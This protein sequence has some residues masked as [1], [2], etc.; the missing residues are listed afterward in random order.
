MGK[1]GLPLVLAANRGNLCGG[2]GKRTQV[3]AAGPDGVAAASPRNGGE[4]RRGYIG[5]G[6]RLYVCCVVIDG[7]HEQ[8]AIVGERLALLV[9]HCR[10]QSRDSAV[11]KRTSSRRKEPGAL[12]GSAAKGRAAK[13]PSG[14]MRTVVAPAQAGSRGFHR[15]SRTR[16]AGGLTFGR[17]AV[18]AAPGA[19]GFING[20]RVAEVV[21]LHVVPG[22]YTAKARESARPSRLVSLALLDRVGASDFQVVDQHR[23]GGQSGGECLPR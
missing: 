5:I 20:G 23:V 22:R 17:H 19:D 8:Q 2:A 4:G 6:G 10:N 7:A 14:E 18:I 1:V 9:D 11:A 16:R 13:A 12:P 3:S 15:A 21:Q